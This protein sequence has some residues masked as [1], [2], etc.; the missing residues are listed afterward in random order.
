MPSI[1]TRSFFKDAAERAI[2]TFAQVLAAL[3]GA[4]QAGILDADWT[5]SLSVAG[6][7]AVVSILMS[8][9][10]GYVGDDSPSLVD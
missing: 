1:F 9:G 5:G 3:L 2:K 10:S 6:M 4:N 7:A 8:I